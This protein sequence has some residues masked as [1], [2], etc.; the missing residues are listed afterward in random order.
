MRGRRWGWSRDG[1]GSGNGGWLGNGDVGQRQRW[2]RV[3]CFDQA[4]WGLDPFLLTWNQRFV[5]GFRT[6][7]PVA[8]CL[9]KIFFYIICNHINNQENGFKV[10]LKSDRVA[11][12]KA[13]AKMNKPLAKTS[14]TGLNG[15]KCWSLNLSLPMA[16]YLATRRGGNVVLNFSHFNPEVGRS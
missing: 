12:R 7:N 3:A 13:V 4:I 16:N 6:A 14:A 11:T 2:W 5:T 8:N 1:E 10:F 9:L 15:Y